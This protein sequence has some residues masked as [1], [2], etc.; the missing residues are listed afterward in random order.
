MCPLLTKDPS[1]V[2]VNFEASE[3]LPV[4]EEMYWFSAFERTAYTML[5]LVAPWILR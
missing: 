3:V 1:A 5:G 2:R 4:N